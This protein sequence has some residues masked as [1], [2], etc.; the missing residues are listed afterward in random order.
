MN[1]DR[2]LPGEED[3]APPTAVKEVLVVTPVIPLVLLAEV[4]QRHALHRVTKD[5]NPKG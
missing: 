2:R 5:Q 3:A 4:V 1:T